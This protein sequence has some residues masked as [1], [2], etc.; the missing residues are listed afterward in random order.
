MFHPEFTCKNQQ[1]FSIQPAVHC[2]FKPRAFAESPTILAQVLEMPDGR[3]F[4]RELLLRWN[5]I[6]EH[7]ETISW[8]AAG[9]AG[10]EWQEP[11]NQ[12]RTG[13][14]SAIESHKRN[15][16]MPM[17]RQVR[18]TIVKTQTLKLYA[19]SLP[20]LCSKMNMELPQVQN[21]CI[22]GTLDADSDYPLVN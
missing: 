17:W 19:G 16:L 5:H 20:K 1:R 12:P 15:R 7:Y 11:R 10:T 22:V 14:P 9:T 3:C 2:L 13:R 21:K 8:D 4:H 6:F 18:L